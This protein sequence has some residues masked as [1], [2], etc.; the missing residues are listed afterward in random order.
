L[1]SP[2][3]APPAGTGADAP[4]ADR[5]VPVITLTVLAAFAADSALFV[6][7]NQLGYLPDAPKVAVV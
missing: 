7:V 1:Q 4:S 2:R 3:Q 5:L 6:R